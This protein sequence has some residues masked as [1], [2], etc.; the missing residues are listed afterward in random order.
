MK[1]VLMER[2]GAPAE[3]IRLDDGLEPGAPGPHQALVELVASPIH[4]SDLL[5]IAG[6]YASDTGPLPKVPGKEGVGKV[7]AVGNLVQHLK[8][9]DL[10]PILMPNDGVWQERYLLPAEGLVGLPPGGNV[11]Q[12]AMG[13]ANPASALM[14]LRDI[15]PLSLGDWVVQNAANSSVGQFLIQLAKRIGYRTINVV[16]RDGLAAKLHEMGADVVLV[17]GPDLPKKVVAATGGAPVKLAIDAVAGDASARLGGC[18]SQ[19]GVLCNYGMLS[20][21]NVQVSPAHLIGGGITV[22]GYWLTSSFAKMNQQ[23]RAALFGELISLIASGAIKADVEASY[24][25]D[26]VHDAL[27][28]AAKGERSGKIFLTLK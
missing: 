7:L 1:R 14:M 6:M 2:C 25:L 21:K 4:P 5:T 13:F 8:P 9:G 27:A 20:G 11:L 28:H 16:R 26:R 23:Q 10:T 3:V 17:D 22:R 24:P 18:L 12:Y 15:V 19:G